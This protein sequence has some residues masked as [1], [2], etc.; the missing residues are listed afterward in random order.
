MV[1]AES[2]RRDLYFRINTFPI[3]TPALHERA[4][5]IPLLAKSLLERVDHKPG[6]HLT[7]AALEWLA[8]RRYAGNIREL[9]NLIER[10]SLL[11]DGEQI[12]VAQL[13]EMADDMPEV[14]LRADRDFRLGE[15]VSL[16]EQERRYIEWCRQRMPGDVAGLAQALGVSL[17]TL[18][19]KV[20][21]DASSTA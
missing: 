8:G 4:G 9:R 6:R 21:G 20:Q 7:P 3:R 2:F 13:V 12:D 17:R 11:A 10:A 5:D 15:I 18:Y 19:R 16:D 14:V 1:Q